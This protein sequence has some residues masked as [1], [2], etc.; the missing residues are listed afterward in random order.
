MRVH[1]PS[2]AAD[3]AFNEAPTQPRTG[4]SI[5]PDREGALVLIVDD[6]EDICAIYRASLEQF[7]Y[8]TVTE[9]TGEDGVHTA[10]KVQPIA[11]LMDAEMP[12]IGG[13]EATRR[14]KSDPVTSACPVIVVTAS[15]SSH[16]EEARSAGCDAYFCKPFN[17]FAL[18]DVLRLLTGSGEVSPS[19]CDSGVVKECPCGEAYAMDAWLALPLCGRMR[20]AEPPDTTLELRNCGCGS[21]LALL[22]EVP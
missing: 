17:V 18:H 14:I 13:L 19:S 5:P 8:R 9:S 7:G 1:P 2:S 10:T 22:V 21:T 3:F 16:F 12:G 11:V 6:D 15:G 4:R 20:V